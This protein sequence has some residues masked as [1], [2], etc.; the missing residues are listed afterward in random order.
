M[1]KPAW[2]WFCPRRSARESPQCRPSQPKTRCC[3]RRRDARIS[4]KDLQPESYGLNRLE[5]A[6]SNSASCPCAAA[7]EIFRIVERKIRCQLR[8]ARG[9]K[10][11]GFEHVETMA[12]LQAKADNLEARVYEQHVSG[13]AATQVA[14][15]EHRRVRD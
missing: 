9:V 8:R 1:S 13:N 3:P 6:H 7:H 14:R 2:S 12:L 10:V 11:S 15:Q 5:Q 4:S